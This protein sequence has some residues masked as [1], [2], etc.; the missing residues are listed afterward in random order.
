MHHERE[1]DGAGEQARLQL[2]AAERARRSSCGLQREG[3]RQR[4]VLQ[5]VGQ[6]ARAL[7]WVKLPVICAAPPV[8]AAV[9][10]RVGDDQAVQHDRELALRA[11]CSATRRG[12]DVAELLGALAS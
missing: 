6:Q 1:A 5:L 10:L 12:R 7:G 2:V 3:Q 8:I 9:G 4:A 11:V